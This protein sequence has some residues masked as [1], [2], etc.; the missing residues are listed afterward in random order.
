MNKSKIIIM[1]KGIIEFNT[2]CIVNA[3][4][5]DLTYGSGV[6]GAIFKAAGNELTLACKQI[7]HCNTGEAVIT[8]AFNLSWNKYIIHAVGP[9][10][11]KN[12]IQQCRDDLY[13]AYMNSLKLMLE[14]RC[15]TITFPLISSGNY[16]YPIREVWNIAIKACNK[17]LDLHNDIAISIYF[18][19]INED[20][21]D[22]GNDILKIALKKQYDT[23]T[24]RIYEAVAFLHKIGYEKLRVM[25]SISPS[26][27]NFRTE[28]SVKENFDSTGYITKDDKRYPSYRISDILEDHYFGFYKEFENMSIEELALS[29]L[30]ET[31]NL[32]ELT[33][34]K[35]PKY[36]KW[37][38]EVLKLSRNKIFPYG[39]DD[40][41]YSLYK[42]KKVKLTNG[43]YID[44]P[45][46]E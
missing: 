14:N 16:N 15:S 35:D 32:E 5:E 1:K 37:F 44:L 28:I 3:A 23:P 24:S 41:G 18:A 42:A 6:C 33:K 25:S 11:D 13:N 10:Y 27:S 45:P 40:G 43:E 26:G 9:R 2:E 4:N 36:V 29:I 46:M 7:G 34:G 19:V 12:N 31:P 30:K 20:I 39:F 38:E 22:L 21:Y 17:F 8:K